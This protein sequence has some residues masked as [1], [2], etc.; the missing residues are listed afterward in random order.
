MSQCYLS[1]ESKTSM[2]KLYFEV[3][4]ANHF[5]TFN[6]KDP[7]DMYRNHILGSKM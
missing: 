2:K 6:K 3:F 5:Y 7:V 4:I 1:S